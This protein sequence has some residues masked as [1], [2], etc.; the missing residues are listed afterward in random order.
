MTNDLLEMSLVLSIYQCLG[1]SYSPAC[2]RKVRR[3]LENMRLSELQPDLVI[4]NS[5]GSSS[6]SPARGQLKILGYTLVW[7][8]HKSGKR[9]RNT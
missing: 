9:E 3:F 8:S 1:D 2:S 5:A 7:I 4:M 6:Q